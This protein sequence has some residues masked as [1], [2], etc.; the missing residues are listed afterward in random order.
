MKHYSDE[1]LERA[2]FSLDLEE[3]PAELRGSILAATCYRTPAVLKPWETVAVGAALA[4][5]AWIA[6]SLVTGGLPS[7][8]AQL[9]GALDF[10]AGSLRDGAT[11]MWI[12]VG[13]SV[14]VW[15]SLWANPPQ[16]VLGKIAR[17]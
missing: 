2:L 8:A 7:L 14:A 11:L 9:Q 17:R 10:I 4:V 1:D 16:F 6:W 5:V 13:G 15:L 12:A 3:P